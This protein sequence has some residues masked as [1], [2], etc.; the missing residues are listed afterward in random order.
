MKLDADVPGGAAYGDSQIIRLDNLQ[1]NEDAIASRA[2]AAL[3]KA[4]FLGD[5]DGDGTYLA[6]DSAL[7]SRVVVELDS[8]FHAH[9]WTDPVIVADATRDGTLSG[10]DAS[11]VA[12][13]SVFIDTDE[14]PPLPVGPIFAVM[15]G[16]DPQL[17]IES[18]IAAVLGSSV[19]VPVGLDVL[20]AESV[21]SST[22][23]VFYDTSVLDYL[24]ATHGSS[25]TSGDG[26][27][28]FANESTPGQVRVSMFN[29]SPSD[30]GLQ[31]I[32]ELEFAVATTPALGDTSLLDVE[33]ASAFEGGLTWTESDGN[34]VFTNLPGDYNLDGFVN[35]A[36]YTVWRD[37]LGAAVPNYSGA[38]G[39]GN[40]LVEPADY[41]VWKQHFGE[42]FVAVPGVFLPPAAIE[43]G[44]AS[45]PV[46]AESNLSWSETELLGPD[47]GELDTASDQSNGQSVDTDASRDLE[48]LL[49]DT[50]ME[51]KSTSEPSDGL[52]ENSSFEEGE[53][54][55]ALLSLDIAFED[56]DVS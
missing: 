52:S 20:P 32:S 24:S 30:T 17:I 23:N 26:W 14:I 41:Q 3:H 38:D 54:E 33:P 48:L 31:G 50:V 6:F 12:Q 1:V 37:S 45:T 18:D 55:L 22:H 47:A 44:L 7:I 29:S 40:G 34:V 35:I 5:A 11:L 39:D 19:V 28:L 8:G 46:E 21:I 9:R 4:V 15:G 43:A 56:L 53:E 42:A 49:L 16:V 51:E 13:E 36:D 10:Q 27:S 2:D 25:W